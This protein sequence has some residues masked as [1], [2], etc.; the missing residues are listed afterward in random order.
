MKLVEDAW[1]WN[2]PQYLSLWN[3]VPLSCP[4]VLPMICADPCCWKQ[5]QRSFILYHISLPYND[6]ERCTYMQ[7]IV[8]P[9]CQLPEAN[10]FTSLEHC[11]VF[12]SQSSV[13]LHCSIWIGSSSLQR[14]FVHHS[15]LQGFSWLSHGL[16][17]WHWIHHRLSW[18]HTC[19]WQY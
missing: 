10:N 2:H 17:I 14:L 11:L 7:V 13:Y 4:T 12:R 18:T 5:Q 1:R 8:C 3:D 16:G 19:H 6:R 9:H 15:L